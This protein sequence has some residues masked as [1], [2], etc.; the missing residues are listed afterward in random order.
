[1]PSYNDSIS[2]HRPRKGWCRVEVFVTG[3]TGYVGVPIVRRLIREGHQV[4][5]LAR[6]GSPPTA[7]AASVIRGDLASDGALRQGAR[8]ADAIVHLVGII[9]EDG[10]A[11]FQAIHVEGTRRLLDAAVAAGVPRF[12]HMSALG[13]D[14][15]SKSAY[16]RTKAQAEALVRAAPVRHAIFR[17]SVIFG[18]GGPGPT[19]TSEVATKLLSL[20]L[21]PVFGKGDQEL[22]PVHVDTVA[23]A[24]A[25]AIHGAADGRTLSLAGPT[26]VTM[27]SLVA[28]MA[29]HT[30]RRFRPVPLPSGL[31]GAVLP[32]LARLPGFPLTEHQFHMLLAGSVDPA[33]RETYDL[34]GLQPVP[35]SV[36]D[37]L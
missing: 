23:A 18:P 3:G 8:G 34:L 33:W 31:I 11:T 26:V 36:A 10:G 5:L 28:D 13:A 2:C 9:R 24:F 20:P 6:E 19:F 12:V 22:Q 4:R 7:E 30:G 14:P 21:H 35:F 1:M 29:R 15:H 37:A 17:P 16:A 32:F 25:K 27:R